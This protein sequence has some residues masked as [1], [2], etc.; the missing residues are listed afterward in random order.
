MVPVLIVCISIGILYFNNSLMDDKYCRDGCTAA[1]LDSLQILLLSFLPGAISLVFVRRLIVVLWSLFALPYIYISTI[2]LSHQSIGS[3]L[4]PGIRAGYGIE[5][6]LA[7]SISTILW[8]I[9]HSL[10]I[11]HFEKKKL[12]KS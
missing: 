8:A 5:L 6:G 4:G 11:R 7:L 3:S 10:I 2:F 9:I 12:K 1:I